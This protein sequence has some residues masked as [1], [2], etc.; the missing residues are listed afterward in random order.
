MVEVLKTVMVSIEKIRPNEWNPNEMAAADFNELVGNMEEIGFAQNVMIAKLDGDPDGFEYRIVDG[1]HRFEALRLCDEKQIP[2]VIVDID[3][4]SQKFQ[5]VKMNKL[6]GKL[7]RKKFNSLVQ[8]L[9]ERH[10][11]GDVAERMAFQD[12][13]ELEALLYDVGK[14]LPEGEI[15]DQFDK[16]KDEIKTVDDLT[17]VLNRLFSQYGDTVP[18]NFMVMDFGGKDHIWVRFN[19][20]AEYRA[21]EQL[22]K[23]VKGHGYTFDSFI[24]AVLSMVPV[25]K[26]CSTHSKKLKPAEVEYGE[27]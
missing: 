23:Q 12:Q 19:G 16:V 10:G 14:S 5:T 6:R 26:F 17:N 21:M 9:V 13:S 18:F 27:E 3:E 25:D 11:I 15:K 24:T 8:D 4:D 1:E 22:A 2:C 20:R 7:N